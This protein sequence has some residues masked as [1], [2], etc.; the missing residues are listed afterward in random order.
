MGELLKFDVKQHGQEQ[1]LAFRSKG[2]AMR[3]GLE[4]QIAQRHPD[5]VL[6][7]FAGVEAMTISFAD[8]FLGRF[9]ASVAARDVLVPALLLLGLNEENLATVSICLQRRELA[10]AA[11]IDGQ[12]VL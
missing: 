9:Y 2:R 11:I 3:E 5:G 6:I 8:E 4:D 7:D 12:P 10:A 1:F